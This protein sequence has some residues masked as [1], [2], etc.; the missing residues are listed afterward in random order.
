MKINL[1]CGSDIRSGYVNADIAALPGV[2]VVLDVSKLPFRDNCADEVYCSH[3]AEHVSPLAPLMKEIHRV[4]IPGGRAHFFV[5]H[6]TC[7][8]MYHDPTHQTFF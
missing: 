1:G 8:N 3:V 2:S 5:P 6:F 7:H 4:L